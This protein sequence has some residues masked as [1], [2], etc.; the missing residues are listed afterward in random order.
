MDLSAAQASTEQPALSA[1]DV[2]DM[3]DTL[4]AADVRSTIAELEDLLATLRPAATV[5]E[6]LAAV[7]NATF[8]AALILRSQRARVPAEP[9]GPMMTTTHP[10]PLSVAE[11][12][13][14]LHAAWR[15]EFA[16]PERGQTP[17][18]RG[19]APQTGDSGTEGGGGSAPAVTG[20]A[21]GKRAEPAGPGRGETAAL[22][23][24][25]VLVLAGHAGAGASTIALLVGEAAATVGTRT[26]VIEC[27]DPT[28][29][30]VAAA[31][32]AELGDDGVG[33]RRGRRG[34]L[35]VDRPS[36]HVADIEDVAAPRQDGH[37]V[38]GAS[39]TVVDAGWAAWDILAATS[40]VTGLL[41]TA[42][43]VLVCRAT[44][45][46]VRQ[47][48]Q[49]LAALPGRQPLIAAVGPAK[50][51]GVVS[52][53]SGPL[54]RAARSAG[55]I[56][57]VPLDRQLDVTGVT[58]SPLPKHLTTAGRTLA[59][60]LLTDLPAPTDRQRRAG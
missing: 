22:P 49:L 3:L 46:G 13:S 18:G 12:Q 42:Q 54:L 24:A 6:Q 9:A 11:L 48:E 59:S 58:A 60:H 35:E 2:A 15:G 17:P 36:R 39:L 53:S 38:A 57:A 41:H 51:P 34:E 1:A 16:E 44:V 32:D 43:I 30:G 40:W 50:W 5:R 33:W 56:V 31:T 10:R 55:R 19:Q 20:R 26:R 8:K 29:S 45:P 52:A 28:R 14:A 27:A 23:G 4:D 7:D 21:G 37:D 47:T 25:A